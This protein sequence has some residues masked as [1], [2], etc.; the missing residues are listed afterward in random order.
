MQAWIHVCV[1]GEPGLARALLT[2]LVSPAINNMKDVLYIVAG[3]REGAG[4]N[5]MLCAQAIKSEC[6]SAVKLLR[7][8]W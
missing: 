6:E 1:P 8:E 7:V 3:S 2:F 4:E 5:H